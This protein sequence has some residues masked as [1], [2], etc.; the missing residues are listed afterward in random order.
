M[1]NGLSFA[2]IS[3]DAQGAIPHARCR[4]DSSQCCCKNRYCQLNNGFPKVLVFHLL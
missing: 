4:A 2:C 3:L 1:L